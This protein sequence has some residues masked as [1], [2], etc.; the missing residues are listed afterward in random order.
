MPPLANDTP[1]STTLIITLLATA[2]GAGALGF[3]GGKYLF[4]PEP[5]APALTTPAAADQTPTD[6]NALPPGASREEIGDWSL[7]C[8]A[9]EAGGKDCVAIQNLGAED[10]RVLLRLVAGYGDQA[11]PAIEVNAPLGVDLPRGL[12]FKFGQQ[13]EAFAFEYCSAVSCNATLSFPD[14]PSFEKLLAADHFEIAL[15]LGGDKD[16][17]FPVSLKGLKDAFAKIEKPAPQPAAAPAAPAAPPAEAPAQP[18]AP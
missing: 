18:P 4:Q 13:T 10:G 14:G 11:T 9:R 8:Q 5:P 16:A 3:V 2:I 12:D 6:P 15:R 7:L 17:V 1:T